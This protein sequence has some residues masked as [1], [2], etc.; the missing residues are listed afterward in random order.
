MWAGRPRPL[1][2]LS[3]WH[4]RRS[5][6]VNETSGGSQQIPLPLNTRC[7]VYG[8]WQYL[9]WFKKALY[10]VLAIPRCELGSTWVD[11]YLG[12]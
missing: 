11:P 2:T 3:T 5:W 1:A 7:C 12:R 10:C 4:P 8:M 9:M 6:C